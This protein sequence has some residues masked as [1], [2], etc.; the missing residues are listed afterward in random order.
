MLP[1]LLLPL[2]EVPHT[3]LLCAVGTVPSPPPG[4]LLMREESSG[5][6]EASCVLLPGSFLS[7]CSVLWGTRGRAPFTS[8]GGTVSY[9]I[10]LSLS[11][12]L[13]KWDAPTCLRELGEEW[14]VLCVTSGLGTG[15]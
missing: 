13:W 9:F 6:P 10:I 1:L 4:S 8:S 11:F 14:E 5:C 3:L 2:S 7:I 15:T 12:P